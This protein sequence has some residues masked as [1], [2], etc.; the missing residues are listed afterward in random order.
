MRIET[1]GSKI[2][3]L[4]SIMVTDAIASSLAKEIEDSLAVSSGRTCLNKGDWENKCG[5]SM[6]KSVGRICTLVGLIC[7]RSG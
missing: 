2:E 4:G 6:F 5:N 3:Q 7:Y 1:T